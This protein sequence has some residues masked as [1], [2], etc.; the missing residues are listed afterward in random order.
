MGLP[1]EE[2]GTASAGGLP[3]V[4]YP[5]HTDGDHAQLPPA[6]REVWE[7]ENDFE[8]ELPL[9]V[10]A[11]KDDSPAREEVIHAAPERRIT[12]IIAAALTALIIWL[13][14]PG[15]LDEKADLSSEIRAP[16]KSGLPA[17]EPAPPELTAKPVKD[18]TQTRHDRRQIPATGQL[19]GAPGTHQKTLSREQK[20]NTALLILLAARSAGH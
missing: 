20:A 19:A 16:A 17:A 3:P 7:N 14:I 12:W 4:I 5:P 2:F 15:T 8:C 10:R 1:A 13:G 11:V 6:W 9:I 18:I